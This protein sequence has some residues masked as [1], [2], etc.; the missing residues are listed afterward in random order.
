MS[1]NRWCSVNVQFLQ[2]S[3]DAGCSQG[4]TV[5]RPRSATNVDIRCAQCGKPMMML[6]FNYTI[7]ERGFESI[8]LRCQHCKAEDVRPWPKGETMN[9]RVDDRAPSSNVDLGTQ[10]DGFDHRVD[11]VGESTD[12]AN[13]TEG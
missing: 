7:L 8:S 13:S 12:A 10:P 2:G 9:T 11:L 3:A 1:P 6:R 4:M 5:E